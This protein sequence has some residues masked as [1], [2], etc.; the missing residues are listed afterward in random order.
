MSRYE[1]VDDVFDVAVQLR[2]A[3][4]QKQQEE[5]AAELTATLECFWTTGSEALGEMRESLQRVR[6]AVSEAL[7]AR[8]L[9]LLDEAI[10]G[11]TS[12]LN[13]G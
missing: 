1:T 10:E 7:S 4:L 8:E 13:L 12:L 5:A 11:A 9:A 3:L 6:S 2:D